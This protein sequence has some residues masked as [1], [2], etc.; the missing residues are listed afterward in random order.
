MKFVSRIKRYVYIMLDLFP[1]RLPVGLTAF[2]AWADR[3][4]FTYF[5]EGAVPPDD[6]SFKFSVAAMIMHLDSQSA[7]VRNR[8][9][10]RAIY[11]GAANEVASYVMHDLKAKRDAQIKA[12]EDSAKLRAQLE[13]TPTEVASTTPKASGETQH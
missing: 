6:A 3:L 9:F 13:N 2:N 8:F 7:K 1:S 4:K 10:G 11:K 5:P 12:E